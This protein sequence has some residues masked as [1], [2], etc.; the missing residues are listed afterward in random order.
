MII[1]DTWKYIHSQLY[2]WN[3]KSDT[4]QA[5]F[6]GSLITLTSYVLN[7]EKF[8]QDDCFFFFFSFI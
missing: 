4:P 7:I 6:L 5:M 1:T 8:I 3:P 2:T